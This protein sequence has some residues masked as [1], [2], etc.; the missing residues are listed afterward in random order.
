MELMRN[1]NFYVCLLLFFM[2]SC[3]KNNQSIKNATIVIQ[4]DTIVASDTLSKDIQVS[5]QNDTQYVEKVLEED[6]FETQPYYD[7]NAEPAAGQIK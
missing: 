3:S 1:K 2:L 7:N 6:K 4:K 5:N